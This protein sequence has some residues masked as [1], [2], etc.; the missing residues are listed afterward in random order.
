MSELAP[1]RHVCGISGGK[2][3]AALAIYLKD[4]RKLAN[5]EYFF[6]DTGK[7]LPEVYDFLD[8]MEAYLGQEIVRIG[9]NKTFEHFLKL[10]GNFLPSPRQRW[11]TRELKIKPFEKWIGDA[12][13]ISYVAIR[14]DEPAR[15]GYI[16]TKPNIKA[17]LPFREDGITKADVFRILEESVG[18]PSYYSWRSRSGC[19]FCFF[20]RRGEWQN[21][22]RVH[23]DL[24]E[25]A[26]EFEKTDPA[27]GKTYTWIQGLP[28]ADLEQQVRPPFSGSF[29]QDGA[30]T[31]QDEIIEGPIRS[32]VANVENDTM[33]EA[34][35]CLICHL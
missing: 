35:G 13:A 18:V 12:P 9:A 15:E 4:V 6:S 5:V 19:Y 29:G 22:K 8:R 17:V 1:V 30:R 27:T 28:L 21:L 3:S 25:A 24:F 10:Y 33:D 11:C 14:A 23:P 20:Q 7:E 34:A 32:E 16:S 26:K 31:W 2:D